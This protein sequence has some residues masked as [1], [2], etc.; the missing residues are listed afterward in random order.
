MASIQDIVNTAYRI[1]ENSDLLQNR[2][3][4]CA[5]SLKSH[6]SRLE[7]TVRGS[8][9]G[10]YAVRQVQ[11]AERAVRDSAVRLLTLRT[12]IDRFINDLTK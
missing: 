2:T 7:T 12:D 9:T 5:N 3:L 6:S 1:R 8:K 4:A 10:E 11:E